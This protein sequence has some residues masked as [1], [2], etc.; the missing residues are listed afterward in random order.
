LELLDSPADRVVFVATPHKGSAFSRRMR[1]SLLGRWISNAG[2][3]TARGL[4]G[5]IRAKKIGVIAGTRDRTVTA[6]EALL[7]DAEALLLPYTHNEL[8]FRPRTANAITRFFETS[9]FEVELDRGQ[10][11]EHLRV[12]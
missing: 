12:S 1:A 3:S 5:P 4:D 10:L 9:S 2:R 8:L 7:D 11:T 6:E